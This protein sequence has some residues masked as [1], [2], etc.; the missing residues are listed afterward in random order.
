MKSAQKQL[1]VTHSQPLG[2]E[3]AWDYQTLEGFINQNKKANMDYILSG[4]GS[5]DDY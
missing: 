3:L 1:L 2:E 4:V 5:V